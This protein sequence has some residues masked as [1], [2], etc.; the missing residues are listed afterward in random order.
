MQNRLSSALTNL[1]TS[2][3]NMSSAR[4]NIQDANYATEVSAMTRSNI[5]QQAGTS[6]LAQRTSRRKAC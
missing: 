4:S 6:V 1:G 2:I 5:L 3:T